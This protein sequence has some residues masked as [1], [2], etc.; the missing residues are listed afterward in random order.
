[1]PKRMKYSIYKVIAILA[2]YFLFH[3]SLLNA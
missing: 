3:V 1:M 2:K